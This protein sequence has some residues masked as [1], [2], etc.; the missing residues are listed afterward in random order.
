MLAMFQTSSIVHSTAR[1][2]ARTRVVVDNL[3]RPTLLSTRTV[4]SELPLHCRCHHR[5]AFDANARQ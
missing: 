4:P 1:P 5:T 3:E 2:F